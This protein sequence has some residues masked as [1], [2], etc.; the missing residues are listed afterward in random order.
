[1]VRVKNEEEFLEAS[2]ESMVAHVDQLV[3]IDNLSTDRTPEIARQAMQKH[4]TSVKLLSYPHKIARPG[5]E[6]YS[7]SRSR[8][9][10]RSP[11]LLA[12]FYD[13]CVAQCD[14]S[15]ILKWD[16]DMVALNEFGDAMAEFRASG[17]QAL[18]FSGTNVHPGFTHE[19]GG[20]ELESNEPWEARVFPKRFSRHNNR[21]Q[22]VENLQTPYK[23]GSFAMYAEQPLYLHLK[24]C[25]RD[26]NANRSPGNETTEPTFGA[27]LSASAADAVR[28]WSLAPRVKR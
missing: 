10:R 28:A 21:L 19:M 17:K 6:N 11:Q 18:W 12:N 26:P 15:H 25:K 3:I 5:S 22:T 1:M 9:G 24:A 27:P 16:G 8:A 20:G 23:H 14:G 4:P 2:L 13:W 7:L